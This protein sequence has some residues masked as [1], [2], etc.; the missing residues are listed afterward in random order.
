LTRI[1]RKIPE[2][3]EIR[4]NYVEITGRTQV[5]IG[6]DRGDSIIMAGNIIHVKKGGDIDIAFTSCGGSSRRIIAN[7]VVTVDPGGKC[8][9]AVDVRGSESAAAIWG[10]QT[11]PREGR[12]PLTAEAFPSP[13]ALRLGAFR[14]ERL[15]DRRYSGRCAPEPMCNHE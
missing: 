15:H 11:Q 8:G 5:A 2:A 12:A 4:G 10:A 7:N 6:S 1:E 3:P 9:Y 13:Q 14:S